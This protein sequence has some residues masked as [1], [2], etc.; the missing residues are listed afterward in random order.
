M[1]P[2]C[3]A[4]LVFENRHELHSMKKNRG[5]VFTVHESGVLP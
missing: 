4:A 2:G 5:E 1:P 3:S